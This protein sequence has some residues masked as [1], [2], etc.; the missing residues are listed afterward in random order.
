MQFVQFHAVS[1]MR[2]M[3]QY[4]RVV[5]H[6]PL[7]L[8]IRWFSPAAVAASEGVSILWHD[9]DKHFRQDVTF[10]G[11][12]EGAWVFQRKGPPVPLPP[13][14]TYTVEL[15][16]PLYIRFFPKSDLPL[17]LREASKYNIS[18]QNSLGFKIPRTVMLESADTRSILR[19]M[20]ELNNKLDDLMD[21]MKGERENA[22]TRVEAVGL[23]SAQV[24]FYS[25]QA[26]EEDGLAYAEPRLGDGEER[27]S[28]ACVMRVN[29]LRP[30]GEGAFYKGVYQHM[31]Q[32]VQDNIVRLLFA[33]EREMIQ[34]LRGGELL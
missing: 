2:M 10:A 19:F 21:Y 12:A 18:V 15:R 25:A 11:G 24:V 34:E 16:Q 9:K 28:F 7:T 23:A 6:E 31:T 33:R 13:G 20:V 17:Y 32:I 30:A 4:A 8:D 22:G 3:W 5:K 27:L 29:K 26:L 1:G 14:Y